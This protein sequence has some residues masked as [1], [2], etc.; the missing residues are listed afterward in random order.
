[1]RA[2]TVFQERFRYRKFSVFTLGAWNTLYGTELGAPTPLFGSTHS[3][4]GYSKPLLMYFG[5]LYVKRYARL[6]RHAIGGAALKFQLYL[7]KEVA[8]FSLFS[9][10]GRGIP[11]TA[12][13]LGLPLTPHYLGQR[14]TKVSRRA[15]T[16]VHITSLHYTTLHSIHPSFTIHLDG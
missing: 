7:K 14:S 4:M 2:K 1:M 5:G 9:P 13:N 10:R 16:T 3:N 6:G 12:P 8:K 11:S 15:F